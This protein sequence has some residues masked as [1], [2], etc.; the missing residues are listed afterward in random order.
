[1][2]KQNLT[3]K[4]LIKENRKII[5]INQPDYFYDELLLSENI[6]IHD[7]ISPD[8]DLIILFINNLMEFDGYIPIAVENIKNDGIL[9]VCYPKKHSP[10]EK[11]ISRDMIRKKMFKKGYK[12]VTQI[13]IDEIWTGIRFRRI[14]LVHKTR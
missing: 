10:A 14:E 9:W 8:M 4:L 6:K 12:Q 2:G 1:M 5:F 7:N 3:E 11:D 13:S